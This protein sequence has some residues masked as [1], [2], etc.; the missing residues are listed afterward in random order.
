MHCKKILDRHPKWQDYQDKKKKNKG[1][2]KDTTANAIASCATAAVQED[3][4][5]NE[6][7]STRPLGRKQV[8][9]N[10]ALKR[11]RNDQR[12]AIIRNQEEL[13]RRGNERAKLMKE[14]LKVSQQN[15]MAAKLQVEMTIMEKD[16]ADIADPVRRRWLE[17]A[18]RLI[19]AQIEVLPAEEIV[20]DSHDNPEDA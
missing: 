17:N 12:D 5:D 2:G 13:I 4:D 10:E 15:A 6:G 19:M 8:K 18:Q 11:K 1:K 3:E 20:E 16:P 9:A 14:A 7:P